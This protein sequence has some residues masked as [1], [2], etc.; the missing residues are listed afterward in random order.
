MLAFLIFTFLMIIFGIAA[1]TVDRINF[2]QR[3]FQPKRIDENLPEDRTG[4]HIFPEDT[5]D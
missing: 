5:D 3:P 2:P 1:L 4:A